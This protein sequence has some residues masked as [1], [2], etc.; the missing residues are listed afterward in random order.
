[1]I[2]AHGEEAARR[3][4]RFG[5]TADKAALYDLEVYGPDTYV[6]DLQM[7]VSWEV[8]KPF[9]L[10][11]DSKAIFAEVFS[12]V[13]ETPPIVAYTNGLKLV[14]D[15]NSLEGCTFY[16]KPDNQFG[17]RGIIRGQVMGGH[18]TIGQR[19]MSIDDFAA[20]LLARKQHYIIMEAVEQHE[21]MAALFPGTVNTV[22]V[23]TMRKSDG[24][25]FVAAAC[26]R[27]GS[28]RS[29]IV[30][31]FSQHG[32]SFD[33]DIEGGT[34]REGRL[35]D[36]SKVTHHRDTGIPLSGRRIP[37]WHEVLDACLRAF[38]RCP[39]MQLVGWDVIVSP[40]GPVV[41]EGN[42]NPEVRTVQ[43]HKPL[44]ISGQVRDFY[45]HHSIL[46]LRPTKPL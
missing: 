26:Q 25:A 20:E 35:R 31:N 24:T 4:W 14:G 8:N 18:V 21:E 13:V 32:M 27:V 7:F 22:R 29:G 6:S 38:G 5:M 40:H 30:D 34:I 11:L 45:E 41:L 36:G 16:G 44:L 1:M 39:K 17:G 43:C 2:P 12:D 19:A 9:S 46:E 37:F 15:L 28:M 33:I 23:M 3:M 10:T 42:S